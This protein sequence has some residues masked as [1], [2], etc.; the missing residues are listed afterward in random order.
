MY[1]YFIQYTGDEITF[2]RTLIFFCTKRDLVYSI[3][4]RA[5]TIFENYEWARVIG[6]AWNL[7]YKSKIRQLILASTSWFLH[8]L[9]MQSIELYNI[10]ALVAYYLIDMENLQYGRVFAAWGF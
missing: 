3:T 7:I 10:F 5:V 9:D 8:Y 4:I 6:G 1:R 2:Q